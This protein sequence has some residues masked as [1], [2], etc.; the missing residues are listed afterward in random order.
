[1]KDAILTYFEGEKGG[2][3]AAAAMGLFSLVAAGALSTRFATP[4][5]AELRPFTIALG[6]LGLLELAIGVGLYAKTGPQVAA[7]LERLETEPA[8]FYASEGARMAKVQKAFVTLEI[9]WCVLISAGAI[10]AVT[11]KLRPLPSGIAIAVVLTA[12]FF[13]AFD[14]VAERRGALYYTALLEPSTKAPVVKRNPYDP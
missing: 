14:L 3:L 13:L 7:L 6:V 5:G 2:G 8:A 11:Q 9:V 4:G 10:V 1:M 12:A